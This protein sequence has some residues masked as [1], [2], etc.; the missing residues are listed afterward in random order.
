MNRVVIVTGASG[1][2]G[3]ATAKAFAADGDKVMVNYNRS[4][5]DA[6]KVVREIEEKGGTAFACK[7]DVA[8]YEEVKA[9]V[10]EA[11][12]RWGTVDVLVNFAGGVAT[13]TD[14][15]GGPTTPVGG[16]P[17]VDMPEEEWD[18][19]IDTNLKGTFNCM[20]AVAPCM[21]KQQEGHIINISSTHAFTG[22][23]G[24]GAYSAAKAGVLALSKTAALELG[25]HRIK[26][27]IVMP[28]QVPVPRLEPIITPGFYKTGSLGEWAN[29]SA[30]ECAE[31]VLFVSKAKNI[32]G[33]LFTYDSR[34]SH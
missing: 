5:D 30:E 14:F 16:C 26:V 8:N 17:L 34:I 1:G 22:R 13:F 25:K 12:A 10:E 20:K 32:S 9:M 3:S 28:G 2:L 18:W 24:R 27:N 15:K 11:V 7:A 4:T 21:I 6:E 23:P 31:L 33:Q 29:P 19:Y